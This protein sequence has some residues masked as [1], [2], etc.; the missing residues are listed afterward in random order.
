MDKI[1]VRNDDSAYLLPHTLFERLTIFYVI[2]EVQNL[3]K[4][5]LNNARRDIPTRSKYFEA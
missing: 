2:D 4:T 1:E 3:G 5:F